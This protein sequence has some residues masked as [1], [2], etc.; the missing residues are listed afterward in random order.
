MRHKHDFDFLNRWTIVSCMWAVWLEVM[1]VLHSL[2]KLHYDNIYGT[3]A[4]GPPMPALSEETQNCKHHRTNTN[5]SLYY[6]HF[7]ERLEAVENA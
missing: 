1:G 7:T 4:S 5:L 6:I 3:L 2:N